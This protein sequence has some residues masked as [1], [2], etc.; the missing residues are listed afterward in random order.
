MNI[1]NNELPLPPCSGRK[2][3]MSGVV[4]TSCT[5]TRDDIFIFKHS[6]TMER[7]YMDHKEVED[8]EM[9]AKTQ[10]QNIAR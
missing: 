6:R 3:P 1:P 5:I 2:A 10:Q 7:S 9:Y 8:V 4:L